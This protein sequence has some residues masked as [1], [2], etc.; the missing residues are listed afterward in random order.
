M[1]TV[2]NLVQNVYSAKSLHILVV[3]QTFN[4]IHIIC[5]NFRTIP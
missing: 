3:K 2:N 5:V 4:V 1:H